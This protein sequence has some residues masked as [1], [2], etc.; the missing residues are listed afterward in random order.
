MSSDPGF[1][2]LHSRKTA[3]L[4]LK[5]HATAPVASIRRR[6]QSRAASAVT[7]PTN[8]GWGSRPMHRRESMDLA[9]SSRR[10][11]KLI[12]LPREKEHPYP[13]PPLP[14]LQT[15]SASG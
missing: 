3:A 8:S 12:S 2:V 14:A 13:Q 5:A 7:P 4:G 9:R 1:E 11:K 15:A 10:E 6:H